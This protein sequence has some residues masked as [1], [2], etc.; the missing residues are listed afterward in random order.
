MPLA[1]R[2]RHL[3]DLADHFDFVGVRVGF[4]IV[5]GCGAM[6]NRELALA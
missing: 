2:H 1:N 4:R 5:P 6:L 3:H